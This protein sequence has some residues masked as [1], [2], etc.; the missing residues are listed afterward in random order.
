MCRSRSA[1]RGSW[2]RLARWSERERVCI[3][4]ITLNLPFVLSRDRV[5]APAAYRGLVSKHGFRTPTCPS[6]AVSIRRLRRLFDGYSGRTGEWNAPLTPSPQRKLGSPRNEGT[7][8]HGRALAARD[9]SVRW[10]DGWGII[11]PSQT[12][13]PRQGFGTTDRGLTAP[14]GSLP[15]ACSRTTD[16]TNAKSRRGLPRGF[17]DRRNQ[18]AA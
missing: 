16:D 7:S 3:P 9:P 4:V 2:M 15:S 18:T 10:D 12:V 14:I 8:R 13:D 5:A 1:W 6:Y 17:S 11:A